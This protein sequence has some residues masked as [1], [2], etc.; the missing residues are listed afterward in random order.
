M[1]KFEIIPARPWHCGQIARL[2]RSE[3]C[4][5][6]IAA[7]LDPHEEIRNAFDNTMRPK[8]WLI[9]G[10]LAALGGVAG[11]TL[12]FH[13][14]LWLALAEF[15]G[16]YPVAVVKEARRQ[17]ALAVVPGMPPA[18]ALLYG[19]EKALRFARFLGF[20]VIRTIGPLAFCQYRE[21]A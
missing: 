1:P 16:K 2:I 7:G 4:E 15:A 10:R 8:A 18:T 14:F 19:D 5:A 12:S 9:D 13:A 17:I 11:N 21:A 6:M 3:E 20:G